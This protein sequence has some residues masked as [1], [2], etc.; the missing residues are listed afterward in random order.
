MPSKLRVQVVAAG[1]GGVGPQTPSP[2]PDT[3]TVLILD[4]QASAAVEGVAVQEIIFSDKDDKIV[5]RATAPW[6]LRRDTRKL[7]ESDRQRD[8]FSDLGTVPF[9]GKLGPDGRLRL[10][11]HAPLDTRSEARKTAPVRARALIMAAG[12][13]GVWV[14]CP[15]LSPWPS[16]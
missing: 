14:D 11:V 4:V 8:D 6:T 7:A 15:L 9:D 10:R 2:Y 1:Y 16:G 13:E 5:A 3:W 12:D